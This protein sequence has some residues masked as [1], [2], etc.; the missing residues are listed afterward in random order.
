[1]CK[2]AVGEKHQQRWQVW[3]ARML[4]FTVFLQNLWKKDEHFSTDAF[5]IWEIFTFV[6]LASYVANASRTGNIV[7]YLAADSTV[8][9]HLLC[10]PLHVY[11]RPLQCIVQS[12][13]LSSTY[14]ITVLFSALVR[15]IK[16]DQETDSRLVCCVCYYGFFLCLMQCK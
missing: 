11:C 7:S 2:Q 6:L 10:Y 12:S 15:S 9:V 1:M 4:C 5:S 13:A 14:V 8:L 16:N 3:S